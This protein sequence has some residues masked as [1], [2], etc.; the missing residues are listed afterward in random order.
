MSVFK[1]Y[2][3]R[4]TYPDQIDEDLGRRIGA[5]FVRLL[6]ARRLVLGRDMRSMAPSMAAAFM[7]G[8]TRA[9]ADVI[10]IGLASTPMTYYAIGSLGVDG[11]VQVTASHNPAG[12]I[13]FK[14][15]RAG[16][17]PVSG[18]TGIS[19]MARRVEEPE[20]AAAE[21]SGLV[22]ERD[23]L[24]DFVAHVIGFGTG[25][26]PLR[27]VADFANGMGALAVPRIFEALPVEATLLFS[28]LDGEFPNHE[29]DP[30]KPRN[31][32]WV[33]EA[34]REKEA[35]LGVSFDGDADR[36]VFVDATGAPV[37]ADFT[38]ALF[39]QEFLSRTPRGAVVY[40][41]RSSRATA[42][43]I[44]EAGGRPIRERVGHSFI[45]AT[46]RREEA[47]F[48]GELSGHYYFR[49]HFV[50]D[51]AEI[52]LVVMLS[53]LSRSGRSLAELVAP[54]AR[55]RAT[56]EVNFRVEDP[57]AILDTLKHEFADG[58]MDEVDGVTVQYPEWWFNVRKSN[59]EPLV[60]LNL[61]ADTEEMMAAKCQLL[62]EIL[63]T[64]E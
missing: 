16:C 54:F 2:D 35:D 7:E 1:A 27:I 52:A 47:V 30:L 15:C 38:T 21:R 43:A 4:G 55:Y 13:G 8:A 26:K 58:E 63:G 42:E 62:C 57:D 44:L 53:I 48:G 20:P 41:L 18:E 28:E 36:C 46:M 22:T 49:D 59:T 33:V 50:S 19:E 3:V 64:P 9:G 11:G 56:G 61:E 40:D 51:S 17:V 5:A 12:Y 37:R 14:F 24:A 60:R 34:V 10:D 31:L 23:I 45:K 32:R 39:A 6:G 25:I 29:A